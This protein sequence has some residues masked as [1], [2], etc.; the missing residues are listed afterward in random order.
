MITGYLSNIKDEFKLYPAALQ[1]G[2]RYLMEIDLSALALGRHS[3]EGNKI[4]A[5]VSEYETESKTKRRPEAHQKYLDIQ[6]ICAGQEM[7]G[8]APLKAAGEITENL[9][10]ERDVVYYREV[11]QETEITLAAGMFAIYFPWDVHRPNCNAGDQAGRVRKVVVK[12][13]IDIL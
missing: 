11:L 8:S 1:A 5:S 9:L 6:Y 12:V 2:F 4:Y 13:A 10:A 7:I 3:I